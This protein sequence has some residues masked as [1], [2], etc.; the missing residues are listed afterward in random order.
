MRSYSLIWKLWE[1]RLPHRRFFLVGDNQDLF[2]WGHPSL[3]DE[4]GPKV[5]AGEGEMNSG[6]HS[7]A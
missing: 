4:A 6:A 7:A 1:D 2:V 3:V 5:V